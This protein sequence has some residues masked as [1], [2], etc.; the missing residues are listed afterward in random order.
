MSAESLNTGKTYGGSSVGGGPTHQETVPD[1]DVVKIAPV[2][3]EHLVE[4]GTPDLS[5]FDAKTVERAEAIVARYPQSRSALLPMLHL[6]QSVEGRV[7]QAGIHFCAEQLGLTP[8]EVSAVATFYTMYKRKTCGEHLVSVCT[9]TLCA[10]LGGDDIYRRLGE[11]LGADGK[12]LGHNETAGEPG[13]P[14]SITL[15]H[16]EC[17]AA[18]DLG[19]VIQVNYEYFDNQTVDSAVELVDKLRNGERPAPTRGA[20]LRDFRTAELELAGFFPEDE[21]EYQAGVDGPSAAV[22]TLRGAKLAHER[23]WVAP[24]MPDDVALPEVQKK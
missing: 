23:G 11:H 13:A 4:E 24:A 5:V 9:N 7:S 3:A 10:V 2:P 20:P 16:A 1:V 19:P 12:R 21:A 8:A 14:G 15:E 17:L 22:E 6:V 18:C